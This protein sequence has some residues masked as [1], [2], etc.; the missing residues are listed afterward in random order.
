MN[1]MQEEV[2]TGPDYLTDQEWDDRNMVASEYYFPQ[3][4]GD[5]LSHQL[6]Q[7]FFLKY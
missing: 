6:E 4:K 3:D 7:N 1:Y 2:V 5:W